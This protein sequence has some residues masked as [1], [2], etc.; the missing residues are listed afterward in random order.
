MSKLSGSGSLSPDL[1]IGIVIVF[2]IE[3]R[4]KPITIT[5]DD[6]DRHCGAAGVLAAAA[7]EWF[8][9]AKMNHSSLGYAWRTS[10][11]PVTAAEMRAVRRS[12]SNSITPVAF[13]IKR[14]ILV[15]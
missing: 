15:K 1:V 9:S 2:V 11:L 14:L 7:P 8:I 6:H 4:K 5:N 10:I 3:N 12:L 13:S